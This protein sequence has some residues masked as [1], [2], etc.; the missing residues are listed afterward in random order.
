MPI[1]TVSH[2]CRYQSSL[3]HAFTVCPFREVLRYCSLKG[4]QVSIDRFGDG[5]ICVNSALLE[6]DAT[7]TQLL[8]QSHVMADKHYRA[9]LLGNIVHLTQTFPLESNISHGQHLIHK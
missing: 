3:S 9:P 7:L 1:A 6:E 2:L 4:L 8:Q 5:P